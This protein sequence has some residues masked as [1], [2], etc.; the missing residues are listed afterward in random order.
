MESKDLLISII[1]P[2]F[3]GSL[4]FLQASYE[5]LKKQTYTDWEWC[6]CDD[7]SSDET[8]IDYL[9]NINS[10]DRISVKTLEKNQGIAMATNGA[11][12]IAKGEIIAF[13][14]Y[15]DEL[16][17]DALKEVAT[18]FKS[19]GV[20]I[21]YTDE[22]LKFPD[23]VELIEHRKPRYSP[24]YLL[25]TNYICHFLAVKK[26]L[27]NALGGLKPG[28]EGAQDHDLVLRLTNAS[29]R[30]FHIPKVLY[31]WRRHAGS[32]SDAS[33]KRNVA[34]I[35][36]IKAVTDELRRRGMQAEVTN[37]GGI[38]HYKVK[39]IINGHPLVSIV[40]AT[41]ASDRNINV[42]LDSILNTTKYDNYEIIVI[43]DNI[44]TL[45]RIYTENKNIKI[46]H[47]KTSEF[48]LSQK[49]NIGIKNTTGKHIVIMHDD[50]RINEADW[51]EWLLGFS[52]D[53]IVGVVGCKILNT[54]GIVQNFGLAIDFNELVKPLFSDLTKDNPG[55]MGRA[56][57]TQNV[58][59]LPSCLMMFKREV[60]DKVG[61]FDEGFYGYHLDVDFCLRTKDTGLVNVVV[62]YCTATH[63][64]T[65]TRFKS[66]GTKASG[67]QV[68][69]TMLF[70]TKHVHHL[71][72]SDTYNN[73]S[74]VLKDS[75]N[76]I[77]SQKPTKAI[78]NA[79]TIQ[80]D[81]KSNQQQVV[82]SIKTHSN[83]LVSFIV[84]WFEAIPVAI[85]S[86]IAQRYQ[87]IEIIVMH[88]GPA[89]ISS[90]AYIDSFSDKR[91]RLYSTPTRYAD[92]G[93]TPRDMGIDKLSSKSEATVFTGVDNY[94][95]PSF[96]EEVFLPIATNNDIV[97]SYCN[98]IHNNINWNQVDTR[99]EYAKIDC[100]CFIVRSE[101][102][103]EF[104]WG[105]RVSW[106]DWVFIEKVIKKYGMRKIAKVPRMLY[107]HN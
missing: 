103:R 82:H 100:G 80:Q 78:A 65:N 67:L 24:H 55:D 49:L 91:I 54:S 66:H 20:D 89:S 106:E 86:L 7:G 105:N 61:G 97:A 58:T 18:V 63:T 44:Q 69:D 92:W 95:I 17:P 33:N 79:F 77:E 9:K 26:D 16:H 102:A 41:H 87:N 94:Y 56:I 57:L 71:S 28:F 19:H 40:I 31:Y 27:F 5:S 36:G 50:T 84:P 101:I 43:S 42:T 3:N 64:G 73:P 38:T 13:L 10:D 85:P 39:P 35:S 25:S 48:K 98:M 30:I 45:Q 2:V 22:A 59:A 29:K 37:P 46:I 99:L 81:V 32:F 74:L 93:H 21:V 11:V 52:Q 51:I 104:R 8:I 72:V 6:I 68:L 12:S 23:R 15:D 75:R 53:P 62:P 96:T 88:D 14:D 1:T 34:A 4:E 83:G 70:K 90:K 47:D 76:I 107:I 60:F